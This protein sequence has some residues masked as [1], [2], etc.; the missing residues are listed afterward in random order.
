M[1]LTTIY[2]RF[3]AN[4]YTI[5]LDGAGGTFTLC[6]GTHEYFEY[7]MCFDET[8]TLPVCTLAGY[9]F[10]GWYLKSG[11]HV[12]V[13]D[14]EN[15]GNITLTAKYRT[16]GLTYDIAYV[17]NGGILPENAPRTVAWGQRV[18]LPEPERKGWLF[19]GWN[20][21]SDGS[22][23]YMELT[24]DGQQSDLTLYAVWQEIMVSGSVENFSYKVGSESAVIT[25]GQQTGSS[26]ATPRGTNLVKI[27]WK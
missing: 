9:D 18:T 19:L 4:K 13:I 27:Y 21:K 22:G 20:T 24:P 16:A 1:Q 2:T 23:E 3:T 17:L 12:E 25:A 10:L 11:E 15:I 26:K 7:T 14:A 5:C 6:D 8:F